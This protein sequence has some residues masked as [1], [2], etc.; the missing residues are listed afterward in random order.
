MLYA[1]TAVQSMIMIHSESYKTYGSSINVVFV[2]YAI[3]LKNIKLC[4]K[5]APGD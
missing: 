2:C 4:T 5:H 1:V 3:K